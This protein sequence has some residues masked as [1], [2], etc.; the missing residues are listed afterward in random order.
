VEHPSLPPNDL[1]GYFIYATDESAVARDSPSSVT[2]AHEVGHML[3]IVSHDPDDT[4]SIMNSIDTG[5]LDDARP[6]PEHI[7]QIINANNVERFGSIDELQEK[8][9]ID[10]E[11]AILDWIDRAFNY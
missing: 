7:R 2:D 10:W 5:R 4:Y 11:A 3:G 6:T 1:R 9:G 8:T